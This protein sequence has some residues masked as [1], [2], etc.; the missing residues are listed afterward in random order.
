M[1]K[2][3]DKPFRVTDSSGYITNK[4]VRR[5]YDRISSRLFGLEPAEAFLRLVERYAARG[6]HLYP[7]D[8]SD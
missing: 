5:A 2:R 6:I 3:T 8:M 1:L 4:Y 7:E